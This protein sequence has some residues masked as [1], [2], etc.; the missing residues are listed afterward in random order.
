MGTSGRRTIGY[1]T[2]LTGP[3]PRDEA[4]AVDIDDGGAVEGTLLGQGA[5]AG[6]V[7]GGVL[8]EQRRVGLALLGDGGVHLALALP[9]VGVVDEVRSEA[10]VHETHDPTVCRPTQSPGPGRTFRLASPAKVGHLG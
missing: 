3:M 2:S 10:Q 5:L 1:P 9:A 4:T 6:G 8:E 7:D